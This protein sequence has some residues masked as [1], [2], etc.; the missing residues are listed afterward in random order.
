ME[1]DRISNVKIAQSASL[2]HKPVS[3]R[4]AIVLALG[5]F[6]SVVCSVAIALLLE[7]QDRSLKSRE[8]IEEQLSLPVLMS[9]P[10]IS[11]QRAQLN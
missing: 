5:F 8:E 11:N 4:K 1:T 7:S 10:R 9:I 3:P 6:I 2:R